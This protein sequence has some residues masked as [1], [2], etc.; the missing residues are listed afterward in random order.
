MPG[1]RLPGGDQVSAIA[2]DQI[3]KVYESGVRAVDQVSLEVAEGE[4]LVLLGPA[5]GGKPP[6]LRL[7]AGLEKIPAGELTL[8]GQ[9]ATTAEP[10]DRN[11]A[12]VFQHSAL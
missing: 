5:G 11:V 4:L 10:G 9:P 12:M 6:R 2:L 7:T 3:T 8:D 1:P